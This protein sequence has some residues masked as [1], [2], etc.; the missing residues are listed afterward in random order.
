MSTTGLPTFD[1]TLQES[2]AWLNSLMQHLHSEDR[3]F[4]Y[5]ALR[6]TLHALRDRVGPE[7]A[8]H[9]AAQLPML[10]RGLFY[11][12]WHMAGSPTREHNKAQFL[13]RVRQEMPKPLERDAERAARAV[14]EVVWEKMDAG[15]VAKAIRILPED[16]RDLWPRIAHR[17]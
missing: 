17:G 12:G 7:N 8:S 10:L 9:F 6:A 1:R 5:I 13:D 15:A 11:E 2:N 4:A 14:F 3:H 16:V